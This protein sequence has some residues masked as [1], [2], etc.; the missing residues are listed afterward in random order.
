M[1]KPEGRRPLGRRRNRW[2]DNIKMDLRQVGW[3][4]VMAWLDLAQ[5]RDRWWVVVNAAM[6]LGVP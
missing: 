5:D 3:V 1:G 6:N 2:K 4:G